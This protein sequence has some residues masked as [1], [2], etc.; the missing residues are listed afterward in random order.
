MDLH[1]LV[2]LVGYAA[3]VGVFLWRMGIFTGRLE[4]VLQS[5]KEEITPMKA[6]EARIAKLEEA[7]SIV[8]E[9]LNKQK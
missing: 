9:I 2:T 3:T 1:L 4:A 8:K 7:I 6:H 5:L